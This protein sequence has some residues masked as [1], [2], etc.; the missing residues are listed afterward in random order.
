M[1]GAFEFRAVKPA[2]VLYEASRMVRGKV[3]REPLGMGS[4]VEV[5]P[6]EL[7]SRH[8]IALRAGDVVGCALFHPRG[9]EGRLYQMAVLTEVQGRGIGT[10][11]VAMLEESA[12]ARGITRIFLHARDYAVGFYE[13][14]G[15]RVEG[16]PFTEIGIPHFRMSK[17]LERTTP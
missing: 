6:F 5:F 4:V 13:R 9:K 8:F 7:D 3:L 1:T 11:L 15:Y 10:R 16:E 17:E 12:A 14:L 2:G